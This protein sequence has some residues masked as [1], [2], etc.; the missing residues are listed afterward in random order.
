MNQSSTGGAVSYKYTLSSESGETKISGLQLQS[1]SA[2][3]CASSLSLESSEVQGSL[4]RS[5][6]NI[7]ITWDWTSSHTGLGWIPPELPWN[8]SKLSL[9]VMQ[10]LL[11]ALSVFRGW[12]KYQDWAGNLRVWLPRLK[13][14]SLQ[15]FCK[16]SYWSFVCVCLFVL[17]CFF[18]SLLLLLLVWFGL[19]FQSL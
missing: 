15:F 5:V 2:G 18:F 9:W 1:C 8:W 7:R 11:Q 14:H 19:V 6:K 17:F 10:L 3:N 12:S 13:L 4:W 16:T